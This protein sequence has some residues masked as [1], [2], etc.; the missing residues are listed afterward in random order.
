MAAKKVDIWMPIYI[1]CYL[2]DTMHLTTE[3]HG[4]YFLLLVYGWKIGGRIP[5]DDE[6]LQSI[7][8]ISAE[9]WPNMRRALAG[10]F[11]ESGGF[12][13]QKRQ[14]I[15]LKAAAHRRK[16]S[17]ENGKNGGRPTNPD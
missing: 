9:K 6:S 15:E 4:A 10:F 5:C 14:L 8:K 13:S 16:T 11:H 2:G 1:G 7:T 3:Q 17:A 12:W